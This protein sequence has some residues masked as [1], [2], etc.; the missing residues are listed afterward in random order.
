MAGSS[1][2]MTKKGRLAQMRFPCLAG[3]AGWGVLLPHS[4]LGHEAVHDFLVAGLVEFDRE[5]VFLDRLDGAVAEFLVEDAVA[6]GEAA[7]MGDLGAARRR[8][9]VDERRGPGVAPAPPPGGGGESGGG[10]AGA[11]PDPPQRARARRAA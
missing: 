4:C 11:P 10:R 8:A 7:D 9:A 6:G 2:A 3:E 5:L 1:P